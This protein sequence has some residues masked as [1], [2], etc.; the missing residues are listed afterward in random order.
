M[1]RRANMQPHMAATLYPLHVPP[2]SGHTIGLDNLTQLLV[3]NGFDIVLIVADHLTR[4][5][6]FL[7][8]T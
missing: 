1:C 6:N 4:M 8:C 7:P 5:A 2:M 3:S